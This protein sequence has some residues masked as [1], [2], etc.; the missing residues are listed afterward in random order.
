M[1]LKIW[2]L[3]IDAITYHC[4]LRSTRLLPY[5]A[6]KYIRTAVVTRAV[7]HIYFN[8]QQAPG[9]LHL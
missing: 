2:H 5:V 4:I 7:L 9:P 8:H 6:T 1:L 3:V